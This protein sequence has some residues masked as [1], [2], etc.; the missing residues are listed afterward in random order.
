MPREIDSQSRGILNF[1]PVIDFVEPEVESVSPNP[2]EGPAPIIDDAVEAEKIRLDL[3]NLAESVDVLATA[4]QARIDLKA[5]DMR[6]KLD[7]NVD[8]A[9][10]AAIRR[11]FPD[12]DDTISYDMYKH[13]R[14]N[15]RRYA[16]AQ[17]SKNRITQD[18]ID[19]ATKDPNALAG[20]FNTAAAKDGTM[21]PELM[22]KAQLIEP[23]D[24]DE[25]QNELIKILVNFI[26]KHF[27]K[28]TFKPIGIPGLG[29]I[30][31][32]LPDELVSVSSSFKNQM[33]N[34]E[35]KGVS[36]L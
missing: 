34:A 14:E 13:C 4:V 9:V 36:F 5:K 15:I 18:M 25:F 12:A 16:D 22:P 23:L 33:K 26:W 7:S 17:A 31:D 24:I 6:I 1:R 32:A 28:P 30:A 19:E 35:K 2:I 11:E 20:G 21:R 3:F 27:I 10:I 29:S 8:A